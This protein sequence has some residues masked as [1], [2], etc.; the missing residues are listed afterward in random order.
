MVFKCS[1]CR[2]DIDPKK[3]VLLADNLGTDGEELSVAYFDS[4]ECL[5]KWMVMHR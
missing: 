1:E 5:K 2:N 3:V 4:Y